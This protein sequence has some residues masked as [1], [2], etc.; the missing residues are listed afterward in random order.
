MRS[1][2]PT[3]R[4]IAEPGPVSHLCQRLLQIGD[5]EVRPDGLEPDVD[6]IGD[7]GQPPPAV[8]ADDHDA[9]GRRLRSRRSVLELLL[10][11]HA[12]QSRFLTINPTYSWL[13]VGE[14][15]NS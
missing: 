14:Q 4:C 8:L 7:V 6:R 13:S 1:K 12:E 5:A 9:G 3:D 15:N 2:Y 10:L 11:A